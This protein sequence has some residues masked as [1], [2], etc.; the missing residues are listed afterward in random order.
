MFFLFVILALLLY[1]LCVHEE[2]HII[3]FIFKYFVPL[4][5]LFVN[6]PIHVCNFF[7]GNYFYYCYRTMA[8]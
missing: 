6:Q 7:F 8:N 4:L 5:S 3:N 2:K 1:T